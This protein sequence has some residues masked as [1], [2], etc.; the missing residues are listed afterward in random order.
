MNRLA[1]WICRACNQLGLRVEPDFKV[2]LN[3][4]REFPTIARI[5]NLGAHN[6][7][8]VFASYDDIVDYQNELVES[9][10]AYAVLDE[11]RQD[12]DFEL[13]SFRE[14][15]L[16]WGWSGDPTDKPHWM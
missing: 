12:E 9:G 1:E 7:M 11:P 15:F 6:G 8:L 5:P 16:D 14:M 4:G 13:E 10:Y 2:V 3:G